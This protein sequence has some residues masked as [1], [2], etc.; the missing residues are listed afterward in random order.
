MCQV[1]LTHAQRGRCPG[2]TVG[3]HLDSGGT[4]SW[5]PSQVY[6]YKKDREQGRSFL[7]PELVSVS[8]THCMQETLVG[9]SPS[10]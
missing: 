5:I 8:M 1:H 9:P 7:H 10:S 2:F 3:K 6:M 4:Q